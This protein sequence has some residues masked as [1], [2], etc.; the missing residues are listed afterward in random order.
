MEH[1]RF[2][3]ETMS[4]CQGNCSGC[5]F[6]EAERVGGSFVKSSDL[7]KIVKFILDK[8]QG[9]SDVSINFG[10]GDHLA[11]KNHEWD[12]LLFHMKQ[13]KPISPLITVTT[14]AIERTDLVKK[15]VDDLHALAIKEDMKIFFAVV[16]D[17]KKLE[18]NSF[19]DR[20][21]ENINYMRNKFGFIDLTINVG[22]D[23]LEYMPAEKLKNFMLEHKFRHL[24]LNLIPTINTVYK[25]S[26]V[27]K[28]ILK[29]FV[30]FRN[31]S[32]NQPYFVYHH[33]H[34]NYMNNKLYTLPDLMIK[35]ELYESLLGN[36]YIDAQ[37]NVSSILYGYTGNAIPISEKT[38]YALNRHIDDFDDLEF[39]KEQN[40][41]AIALSKSIFTDK[42]C[43]S[44]KYKK[45]CVMSGAMIFKG[46]KYQTLHNQEG[47][48]IGV[49]KL[50]SACDNMKDEIKGINANLIPKGLEQTNAFGVDSEV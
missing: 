16:L 36:F 11:I 39:K 45:V 10:Q 25:F 5:F 13:F 44:C 6:S 19:K 27:Y 20:Y 35:K 34:F 40:K 49:D 50:W 26:T 12:D 29:W 47:C 3:V 31:I 9:M 17:P 42:Q 1:N 43:A 4:F 37:L 38:G 23:T 14:S 30:D 15:R 7:K 22:Q 18:H 8:A 28:D 48:F 32:V 41:I 24:E 46:D 33:Y 21:I 2:V